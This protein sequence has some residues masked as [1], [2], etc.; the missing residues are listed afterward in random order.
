MYLKDYKQQYEVDLEDDD[1][2]AELEAIDGN[3]EEMK[4]HFAATLKFGTAGLRVVL[5]AVFNRMNIY[6][7][8]Q[9]TQGLTNQVK[10]R[11]G[12]Q[13]SAMTL[14]STVMYL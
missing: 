8:R 14:V 3:E 4:T 1:L 7:I 10:T 5:G 12:N 11:G 2:T 9:V 6:V 13:L